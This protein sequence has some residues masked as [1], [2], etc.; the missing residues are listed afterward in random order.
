MTVLT[1]SCEPRTISRRRLPSGVRHADDRGRTVWPRRRVLGA[2]LLLA[3]ALCCPAA[4]AADSSSSSSSAAS[5]GNTAQIMAWMAQRL[6]LPA[7][8]MTPETQMMAGNQVMP[9]KDMDPAKLPSDV[10]LMWRKGEAAAALDAQQAG[11]WGPWVSAQRAAGESSA[12]G[13]SAGPGA[14]APAA[15]SDVTGFLLPWRFRGL[16]REAPE[17]SAKPVWFEAVVLLLNDLRYQEAT[18]RF[19]ARVAVAL[20]NPDSPQERLRLEQP[21]ALLVSANADEVE[22]AKVEIN[23]LGD[24][25]IVRIATAS[26]ASPFYVSAGTIGS[27]GD[28]I[29]IPVE[30]LPLTVEA[31]Q[32]QIEGW[33]LARTT[34]QVSVPGQIQ[35]G[36]HAIS[37]STTR[38]EIVPT[39]VLLDATGHGSAQL[40]SDGTGTASITAAGEPYAQAMTTVRFQTPINFLIAAG[41]GALVG[42]IARTRARRFAAGSLL[43]AVASSAIL[44]AAY[45]IGLN[46]M[47]WAP[48]AGAGEALTFFVAAMGAYLGLRALTRV[49]A[50][51][52]RSGTEEA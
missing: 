11:G 5:T 17:A 33:G 1:A 22:P 37:L 3:F 19:E 40:R 44:T 31:A 24:P 16:A 29:E 14:T 27:S 28:K 45:A 9:L 38:G 46:W 8:D 36:T 12:N 10:T 43:M 41:I 50:E 49:T 26:P 25:Q 13:A 6:Q 20:S 21:L 42:W 39:P 35:A 15:E 4:Y 18:H 32:Q 34:L 52:S 2:A 48:Q 47:R 23:G 7:S 30:R 51:V